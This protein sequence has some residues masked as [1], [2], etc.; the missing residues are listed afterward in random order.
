MNIYIASDHA[1]FIKK[2]ELAE[3]LSRDFSVIDLGPEDLNPGDD[4]PIFAQRVANSVTNEEGSLGILVCKSG[5]GME[6]AA[7]KVDGV[8]AALV[9]NKHI[10]EET[11][12][13]NDSNVLSLPSGE[14][15]LD[16]MYEI[17][18][19]F[20]TTQFSKQDRHVRRIEEIREIEDENNG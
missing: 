7:N 13:D 6:I 17:S 4:Y 14:L 5:Q 9:W 19:T 2:Q 20:L 18:K 10:A 11:R 1:G 15:S 3:K 12:R 8:R 16:E